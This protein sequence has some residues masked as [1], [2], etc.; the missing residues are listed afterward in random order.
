MNRKIT[1][2]FLDRK[3]KYPSLRD[4]ALVPMAHTVK[5]WHGYLPKDK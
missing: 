2:S 5:L 3:E 4:L 1:W